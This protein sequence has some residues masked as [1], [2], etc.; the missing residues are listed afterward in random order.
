MRIR[1]GDAERRVSRAVRELIK[2]PDFVDGTETIVLDRDNG[3][4]FGLREVRAHR[5]IRYFE[6]RDEPLVTI[7]WVEDRLIPNMDRR[8]LH[9]L[10]HHAVARPNAQA[11]VTASRGQV[12]RNTPFIGRTASTG[13]VESCQV[14]RAGDTDCIARGV[15][16]AARLRIG[17]VVERGIEFADRTWH[18][19]H[20]RLKL[21]DPDADEG[22]N[23]V[24]R[25][26]ELRDLTVPRILCCQSNLRQDRLSRWQNSR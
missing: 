10:A 8:H 6:D 11:Y 12:R 2:G 5:R 4:K 16:R 24:R 17:V 19:L 21:R 18:G 15:G 22:G 23:L 20:H 14:L 13:R 26:R 1:N 3:H 9:R 7:L 25:E